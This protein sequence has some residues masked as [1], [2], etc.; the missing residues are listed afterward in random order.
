MAKF[1]QI[2][3]NICSSDTKENAAIVFLSSKTESLIMKSSGVSILL[4]R[5]E[6][7]FV[8]ASDEVP[9]VAGRSVDI[10]AKVVANSAKSVPRSTGWPLSALKR[11][12]EDTYTTRKDRCHITSSRR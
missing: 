3:N 4:D 2:V 5:I 7:V 10:S 8:A 12:A 11:N 6:W 9:S 1:S